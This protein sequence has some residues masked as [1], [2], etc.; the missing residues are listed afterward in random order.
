MALKWPSLEPPCSSLGEDLDVV[1]LLGG[2]L[3]TAGENFVAAR[4]FLVA[5][6]LAAGASARTIPAPVILF[7]GN[8]MQP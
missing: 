5:G 6:E 8:I 3:V 2:D 7:L 4:G 1:H